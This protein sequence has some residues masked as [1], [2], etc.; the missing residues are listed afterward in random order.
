MTSRKDLNRAM[1]DLLTQQETL[2]RHLAQT[3]D[4]DIIEA[5]AKID[6]IL[7]D[8]GFTHADIAGEWGAQEGELPVSLEAKAEPE[9]VR[10][11][12][13]R[14]RT[15]TRKGLSMTYA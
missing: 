14:S 7:D 2:A 8:Y 12:S 6:A 9:I 11:E 10:Q 3:R 15:R 1:H 4:E 13:R 5:L